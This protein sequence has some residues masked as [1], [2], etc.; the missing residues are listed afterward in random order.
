MADVKARVQ[1]AIAAREAAVKGSTSP[2]PTP[3]SAPAASRQRVLPLKNLGIP[4]W[5]VK[6][7]DQN[8][9]LRRLLIAC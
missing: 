4:S 1:A 3:T 6:S 9:A 5:D 7:Q 8:T 2:V